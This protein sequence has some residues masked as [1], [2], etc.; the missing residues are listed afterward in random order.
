MDDEHDD[1][2][3][4]ELLLHRNLNYVSPINN[5][6]AYFQ[7]GVLRNILLGLSR[8][9]STKQ[10]E[11]AA[12]GEAVRKARF[13]WIK[14]ASQMSAA[15]FGDARPTTWSTRVNCR[16]VMVNVMPQTHACRSIYICP[17]CY[18]RKCWHEYSHLRN[19]MFVQGEPHSWR[20]VTA[21]VKRMQSYA[22]TTAEL[23]LRIRSHLTSVRERRASQTF[24]SKL[25]KLKG[26]FRSHK[27]WVTPLNGGGFRIDVETMMLGT[28]LGEEIPATLFLT[29][30]VGLKTR[31]RE[32]GM[33]HERTWY[34]PRLKESTFRKW[35]QGIMRYRKEWLDSSIEITMA[36]NSVLHDM[37]FQQF[38]M[39]GEFRRHLEHRRSDENQTTE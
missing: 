6:C 31:G 17:F 27:L 32:V 19:I 22:A 11:D 29:S 33:V 34:N 15:G 7:K 35:M 24:K 2:E 39:G 38:Y 20:R 10:Q 16:P 25:K 36:Y 18:A 3:D 30:P 28:T 5:G 37:R 14:K 1:D 8:K 26:W 4:V 23:E 9:G 21:N 12:L 13:R